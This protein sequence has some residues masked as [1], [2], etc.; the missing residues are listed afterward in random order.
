M[1]YSTL[2]DV[3]TAYN[4]VRSFVGSGTFDVTTVEISSRFIPQAEAKI[5][6]YLAA[7]YVIPLGDEPLITQICS[8]LVVCALLRDRAPRMPE[9]M[10]NR[11]IEANS[12]LA[13]LRDGTMVLVGSGTT[14]ITSGDQYV[15]S[16]VDPNEGF[17]GPIF[18]P[19]EAQSAYHN[20]GSLGCCPW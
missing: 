13:A 18:T 17:P 20:V 19:T 2:D 14:Q 3:L 12:L 1:P 15:W 8:D 11:C 16:N 9:F 10:N 4:P 5:N 6:A 7:R